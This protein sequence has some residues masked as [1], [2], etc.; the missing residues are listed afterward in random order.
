M[1]SLTALP[2]LLLLAGCG[3]EPV[4]LTEVGVVRDTLQECG[5]ALAKIPDGFPN[6]ELSNLYV[7]AAQRAC[8]QHRV[9]SEDSCETALSEGSVAANS[10]RHGEL[11]QVSA[12]MDEFKRKRNECFAELRSRT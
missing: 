2:L 6:V 8:S 3:S 4:Y 7:D 10:Y 1:K 5:D 12:A 11:G 9:Q